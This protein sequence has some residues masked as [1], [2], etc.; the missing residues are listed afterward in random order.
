MK[1]YEILL[2]IS[3]FIIAVIIV[4]HIY[5][6]TELDARSRGFKHPK[7]WGLFASG[8]QNGEGILLYLIGRRKYPSA[9]TEAQKSDMEKYKKNIGISLVFLIIVSIVFVCMII[10]TEL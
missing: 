7:L 1:W 8:G 2:F 6:M 3:M 5:K 10:F 4:Y 9:M